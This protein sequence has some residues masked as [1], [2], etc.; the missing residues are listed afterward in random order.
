MSSR[1]T[2]IRR[3]QAGTAVT[4]LAAA[5]PQLTPQQRRQVVD[6]FLSLFEGLYTHL[7]LKR[8]MYGIDPIQQLRLLR[9]RAEQVDDRTFHTELWYIVR[10]CRDAHTIYV[11]PSSR[12]GH[13]ARL[14]FLV[15]QYGPHDNPRYLVSKTAPEVI[16]DSQFVP[17]V[18][19]TM[20]NGMPFTTAVERHADRE[21]GGRADAR[22][23]RAVESLTFR[24]LQYGPPPD[25]HWVLIGYVAK[26]GKAREARLPWRLVTPRTAPDTAGP[27]TAAAAVA[28]QA[29]NPAGEQIRRAKKLMFNG[30]LWARESATRAHRARL[31]NPA[32]DTISGR[33]GDNVSARTVETS[34]GTFGY[35]RLWSFDLR[36][37]DGF[38]AEAI[39]ILK[40]LPQSGLI[41]DL[42]ANPGGLIWAAERLLQLFTPHP[43]QPVRFSLAA[44]ELTRAMAEAPQNQG[45]LSPWA[46]SLRS[47]VATGELYSQALPITPPS[48]CN[49]IGQVYGGPVVAVV[50][51]NTYS[52]G[53]L[54]AAGFVDNNVGTLVTV[55]EA[56]G[57]GGAN[58]WDPSIVGAA[59]AGTSFAP[60][61]LPSGITYRISV[62]RATRIGDAEGVAIED[63]G[64]A[65]HRRY[66]MTR[67]DLLHANRDLLEYCGRL[68]GA[69]PSTN[70]QITALSPKLTVTSRGLDRLDVY[71]DDRPL[72]TLRIVNDRAETPL[73]DVWDSVTLEGFAGQ[74]LRQRRRATR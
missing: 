19:L 62:R 53:D 37:D 64:V 25:E 15:E 59:L 29:L 2:T 31:G 55:G 27:A 66:A 33:F 14:P 16:D 57:A 40:R 12:T 41:I 49:D 47:A 9:Q 10:A 44:T 69:E 72:G 35:L 5:E 18:E 42:R 43:V 3:A 68:L 73:P 23:A 46:A 70:L 45:S 67:N 28:A 26:N 11:G 36:D 20:W 24:A 58:V 63:L 51:P 61:L 22:L 38:L 54:F 17:G 56:T 71:V 6:A 4:D 39:E 74:V 8:S 34:S 48:R 32:K 52:A 60:A 65:G 21:T 1:K 50:D 30:E 13:V 7:P